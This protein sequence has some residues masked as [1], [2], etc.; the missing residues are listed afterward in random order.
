MEDKLCFVQFPHPGGEHK[1]D[2]PS[3]KSWNRGEHKRTFVK[4]RG[5]YL[6]HPGDTPQEDDLVFWCEWEPEAEVV[7]AIDEPLPHGPRH[8]FEPYYVLPTSYQGLQNTDPFVFGDHFYYTWCKQKMNHGRSST[9]LTRLD[10]GSVILF[11]SRVDWTFALDTVFVVERWID[12]CRPN[13]KKVLKGQIPQA[14]ADITIAPGYQEPFP[15]SK[16][17]G[18]GQVDPDEEDNNCGPGP[19]PNRL[20]FGA[21]YDKPCEGMFSFFPCQPYNPERPGFERPRI[22]LDGIIRDLMTMSFRRNPQP[23]LG[24][25]KKLWDT[26]VQQVL[27]DDKNQGLRLGV[28]T[29]IPEQRRPAGNT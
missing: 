5:R 8:V 27:H 19:L 21:M 28:W 12:H 10:F 13:Y 6:G 24:E 15:G 16:V 4:N 20:Y 29:A 26:V 11:G 9:Q 25:S 1:P 3:G 7:Q 23:S 14:Y 17:C 22:K 2:R 18:S